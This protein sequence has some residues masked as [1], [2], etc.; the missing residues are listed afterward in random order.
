MSQAASRDISS[1]EKPA[2]DVALHDIEGSRLASVND[3]EHVVSMSEPRHLEDTGE[4]LTA[5]YQEMKDRKEQEKVESY[6]K[7]SSS[8]LR[9]SAG[10]APKRR[11]GK[12]QRAASRNEV[13][14]PMWDFCRYS[15]W[16]TCSQ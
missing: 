11:I 3:E 7:L 1:H 12:E 15:S 10:P 16:P 14:W 6:Q 13:G 5:M 2:Q 8:W 9:F 4:D